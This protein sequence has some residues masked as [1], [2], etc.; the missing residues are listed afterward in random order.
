M[1]GQAQQSKGQREADDVSVELPWRMPC[2]LVDEIRDGFNCCCKV[3]FAD[4]ETRWIVRLTAGGKVIYGVR[5]S[6]PPCLA[7]RARSLTAASPSEA[8]GGGEGREGRVLA[9]RRS[10]SLRARVTSLRLSRSTN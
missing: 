3:R 10:T 9:V 4:D 6:G 1:G 5:K 7:N 2:E 8:G